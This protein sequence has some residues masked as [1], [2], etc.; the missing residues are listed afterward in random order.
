MAQT[1]HSLFKMQYLSSTQALEILQI[2]NELIELCL[3]FKNEGL[4]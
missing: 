1:I 3:I 4:T 2:S